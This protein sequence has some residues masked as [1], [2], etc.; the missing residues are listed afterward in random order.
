MYKNKKILGIIPARGGSKGIL[1]KNIKLINNK[2]LIAWTI[3]ES[4]KSKYL[5]KVIVSTDDMEIRK[6]SKEFG[7]EVPFIRPK[8]LALDNTR[9]EDAVIHAINEL[10]SINSVKY[11]YIMLL[12]PTSP[13]R[14]TF[15][16][17]NAIIKLIDSGKFESLISITKLEHPIFWTRRNKNDHL[18]R[19][20]D[21]NKD[22][23]YRR[24]DFEKLYRLNGAIYLINTELFLKEK[25]FELK[26]TMSFIMKNKYSIDIDEE[27][28]LKLAEYYMKNII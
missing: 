14:R 21:Y 26:N 20:L 16:I 3:E 8:E 22:D 28:D 4:K 2:P 17:D 10:F 27:S 5:D 12:Q 19:V 25:K 24:Q 23:K 18:V 11:D 7:A 13:L 6:I 1:K 15:H 9:S